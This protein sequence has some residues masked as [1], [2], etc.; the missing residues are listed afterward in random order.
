MWLWWPLVVFAFLTPSIVVTAI[1]GFARGTKIDVVTDVDVPSIAYFLGWISITTIV[2]IVTRHA[3]S[4]GPV[5][6][7]DLSR[8][9]YQSSFLYAAAEIRP[10]IDT[11]PYIL[12][13]TFFAYLVAFSIVFKRFKNL[14]IRLV[15]ELNR[16][17]VV[18]VCIVGAYA[19]V[20]VSDLFYSAWRVS[21]DFFI[22]YVVLF[23]TGVAAYAFIVSFVS[24]QWHAHHWFLALM[25]AHACVFVTP[26]VTLAQA[27]F[28]AVHVHGMAVFG[29]DP[30]FEQKK[31][32][33]L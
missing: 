10:K 8:F 24:P 29:P 26:S 30:L 31:T 4:N 21:V 3:L 33:S 5:V 14:E 7:N 16:N 15:P 25:F 23:L 6:F 28:L 2:F 20:F 11:Y 19:C 1:E 27:M 13:P 12:I 9:V 32:A 17:T 22:V 18:A